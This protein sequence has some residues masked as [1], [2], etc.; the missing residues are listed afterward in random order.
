MN[1]TVDQVR[2]LCN[3][4]R[5][6]FHRYGAGQVEVP[7]LVDRLETLLNALASFADRAWVEEMHVIWGEMEV[8]NAIGLDEGRALTTDERRSIDEA[9]EALRPMLVEY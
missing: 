1:E 5:D 4:M 7:E 9:A 3:Q 2:F 8:P 6:V